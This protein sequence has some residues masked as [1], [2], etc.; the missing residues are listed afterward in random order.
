MAANLGRTG[1][2]TTGSTVIVGIRTISIAIENT[3]VEITDNDSAGSKEYL[4]TAGDKSMTFSLDGIWKDAELRAMAAA[5]TIAITDATVNFIDGATL[6][7]DLA[8]SAYSEVMPYND[9]TT[10]TATLTT[11]GAYVYT[12]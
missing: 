3:L 7:G 10:F 5:G 1:N 8:L 6:T 2:I 9:A 11:N 12:P 4:T